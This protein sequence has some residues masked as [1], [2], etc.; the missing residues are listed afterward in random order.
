MEQRTRIDSHTYNVT[1]TQVV[2]KICS[3]QMPTTTTTTKRTTTRRP[4]LDLIINL[5][6]GGG[7]SSDDDEEITDLMTYTCQ[8]YSVAYR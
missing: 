5:I 7:K 8:E 3:T 2:S 4:I 1:Y 6:T